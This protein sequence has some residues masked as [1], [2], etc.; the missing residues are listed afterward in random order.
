MA[1]QR[2]D[3]DQHIDRFV[4][5]VFDWLGRH[6]RLILLLMVLAAFMWIV[7]LPKW[8]VWLPMVSTGL[9]LLFQLLFAVLFMIV[10]FVALF[11]FLGRGRVYL[12]VP[13]GTGGGVAG[14]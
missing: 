11:W 1:A 12:V 9:L 4:D 5:N 14:Y 8:Q 3:I 7:A 13:G 10:Q 6:I 2:G